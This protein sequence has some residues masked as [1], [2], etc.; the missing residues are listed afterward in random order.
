[1]SDKGENRKESD[2]WRGKPILP[3]RRIAPEETEDDPAWDDQIKIGHRAHG[4]E[5]LGQRLGDNGEIGHIR[6]SFMVDRDINPA[7]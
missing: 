3:P 1:M 2:F 5:I 7:E 6:T 4:F